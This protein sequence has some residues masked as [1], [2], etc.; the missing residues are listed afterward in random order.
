M[1]SFL[2]VDDSKTARMML[3]HWIKTLRPGSTVTEAGNADEALALA[4]S[5]KAEDVVVIDYN[6]P[7]KNGIELAESLVNY[8]SHERIVLC[9]ANVQEAIRK[10]ADTMGLRYMPKPVT[11]AKLKTIFEQMTL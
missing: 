10:K 11:P 4:E 9:T 7:G 2:I 3:G 6:M 1:T 5:I 8:I